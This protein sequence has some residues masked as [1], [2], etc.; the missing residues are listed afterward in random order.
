MRIAL[1]RS[2]AGIAAVALLGLLCTPA[3]ALSQNDLL[4]AVGQLG[5]DR[6]SLYLAAYPTVA[7]VKTNLEAR[8]Q[9]PGMLVAEQH[10]LDGLL[11]LASRH[12]NAWNR[13]QS[14]ENEAGH[15]QLVALEAI[16]A[17]AR[18]LKGELQASAAEADSVDLLLLATLD[19]LRSTAD[20]ARAGAQSTNLMRTA[21]RLAFFEVAIDGY[22]QA[23]QGSKAVAMQ[24]EFDGLSRTY[25]ADMEAA[26]GALGEATSATQEPIS[27]FSPLIGQYG[28]LRTAS[29]DLQASMAKLLGHGET[30]RF[31]TAEQS[32][33][34]LRS[35]LAEAQQ[36]LLQSLAVYL[37]I[38][39]LLCAW[40]TRATIRWHADVRTANLGSGI[41]GT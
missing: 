23:G 11:T 9:V 33:L 29:S 4:T 20:L 34:T 22:Q 1:G 32:L 13:L 14:V 7:V 39:I 12:A 8:L 41:P 38:S 2:L 37:A 10:Q 35:H 36:V 21:D 3:T 19:L 30:E 40:A 27:W 17:D 5:G 6:Q 25:Q 31:A 15:D 26:D 28:R 16:L 18:N 24:R